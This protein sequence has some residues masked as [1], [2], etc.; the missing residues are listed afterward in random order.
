[1]MTADRVYQP[2]AALC[3]G[4][5]QERLFPDPTPC[6]CCGADLGPGAVLPDHRPASSDA[7]PLEL[8]TIREETRP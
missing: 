7:A 6:P 1:M 8:W 2:A 3:R 5:G 4:S